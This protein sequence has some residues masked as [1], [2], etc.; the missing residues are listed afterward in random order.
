VAIVAVF[1][2]LVISTIFM[3]LYVY[4]YFPF[5]CATGDY[6]F[7][8][9]SFGMSVPEVKRSLQKHSAI[10]T[11][12]ETFKATEPEI[13]F[14]FFSS[15]IPIYSEDRTSNANFILYMPSIKMFNAITQ[16]EYGFRNKRLNYVGLHFQ[17]EV[18][19][20]SQLLVE[21]LQ[22]HLQKRYKYIAREESAEIPRAY[23]L[24]YGNAKVNAKMW[25]NLTD[26]KKPVISIWLSHLPDEVRDIS[27]IKSREDEAF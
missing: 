14:V 10:L 24:I 8:G 26:M 5:S 12:F 7:L 16:A 3:L 13:L 20:E 19:S 11:D 27:Q 6:A 9:T 2:V 15:A 21:N 23:T 4:H 25:V 22:Q 17:S 18:L 1:A